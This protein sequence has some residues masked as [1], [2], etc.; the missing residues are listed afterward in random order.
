MAATERA[1]VPVMGGGPTSEMG[2]ARGRV[3][4]RQGMF[5]AGFPPTG[6]CSVDKMRVKLKGGL[7]IEYILSCHK[8]AENYV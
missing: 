8:R 2:C 6:A 5:F 3:V 1:M 7:S 4:L